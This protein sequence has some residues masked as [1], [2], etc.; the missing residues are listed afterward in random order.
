LAQ[1]GEHLATFS[2]HLAP[3]GEHLA[4]FR[5]HLAPIREHLAAIGELLA[6][7]GR[8][9]WISF[10]RKEV[11]DDEIYIL[12]LPPGDGLTLAL[13]TLLAE[14]FGQKDEEKRTEEVN[15]EKNCRTWERI[16]RKN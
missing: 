11:G 3:F 15:R 14:V 5:E 16:R 7:G 6:P 2:T 10:P 9:E 8:D 4:P 13:S 1:F 12:I